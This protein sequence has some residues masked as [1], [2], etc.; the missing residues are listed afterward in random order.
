MKAKLSDIF[1]TV[2]DTISYTKTELM[3]LELKQKFLM[4]FANHLG[5]SLSDDLQNGNLCFA[6]NSDIR[7][8]YRTTITPTVIRKY[9]HNQ[10]QLRQQHKGSDIIWFPK[11][12]EL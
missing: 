11:N 6:H 4:D 9:I 1:D 10:F 3:G 8:G 12:I 5:L 7:S 2:S